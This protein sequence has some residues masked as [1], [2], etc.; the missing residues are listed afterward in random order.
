MGGVKVV[1][2]V[3]LDVNNL[4]SLVSALRELDLEVR[5]T[6]SGEDLKP[7][8]LT[9]LPGTGNFAS[10]VKALDTRGFRQPILEVANAGA[11]IIGVCLGA[12]LLLNSSQEGPGAEGLGLIDGESVRL[13]ATGSDRVPVLGWRQV[14]FPN[15]QSSFN[16][17][18]FYF[19]HSYEMRTKS[20]GERVGFYN[21]TSGEEVTA[22]ISKKQHIVGIQFHPEKSGPAGLKLLRSVIDGS[23]N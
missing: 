8:F 12:Q 1:Q 13:T 15:S 6:T 3:D 14:T 23:R 9:F 21:R 4:G 19:A 17:E 10:A 16:R 7:E 2:V 22:M 5:V 11:R 18:W 20:V